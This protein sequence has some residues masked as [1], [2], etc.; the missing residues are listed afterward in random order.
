MSDFDPNAAEVP[1][2]FVDPEEGA[3]LNDPKMGI[4]ASTTSLRQMW[5]D[6]KCNAGSGGF[7]NPK[8]FGRNIGGVA[9]PA[10]D[11]FKAL[12]QALQSAGYK[13][14]S[15]WAYN[16]RNIAGTDKA[17]LHSYGIAID[18]DPK[19][20]PYSKGDPYSGKMKENHVKAALAIKN[21]KGQSIWAWGG[22]WRRPD[23]MHFQIDRDPSNV[24]VDWSTVPGGSG[25]GGGGD[26]VDLRKP[27]NK[28]IRTKDEEASPV[29]PIELIWPLTKGTKGYEVQQV[30]KQLLEWAPDGLPEHGAD[31]AYGDESIELMKKFQKAAGLEPTGDADEL[32]AMLLGGRLVQ[33]VENELVTH[34]QK[35]LLAWN[36][37]ALPE[38][39]A[40]GDFGKETVD[41]LEKFQSAV[42]L[43][44]KAAID[45]A[46]AIEL[47]AVTHATA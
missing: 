18:L 45:V 1:A 21:K 42:G 40:D 10:E 3:E 38:H 47:G 28:P 6:W 17:S 12:E 32:V 13:P 2:E 23:R 30:Q 39:G 4:E 37:G 7:A 15:S 34:F 35:R 43:D 25:G 8:F 33:G 36:K 22:S 44:T 31:G 27:D 24:A 41:W 19:V 20:N 26:T 46:C 11:A 29:A 5:S 14:S 9:A 16:C